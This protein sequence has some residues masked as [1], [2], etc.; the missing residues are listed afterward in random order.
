MNIYYIKFI[1]YDG[2]NTL[3]MKLIFTI[4][5]HETSGS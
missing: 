2:K 4:N 3:H 1:Y 5:F